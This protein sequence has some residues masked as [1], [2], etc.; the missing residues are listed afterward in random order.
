[1]RST[2]L[3]FAENVFI[4]AEKARKLPANAAQSTQGDRRKS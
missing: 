1:L 4:T 3:A 2:S